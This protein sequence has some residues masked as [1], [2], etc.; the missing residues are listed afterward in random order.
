[1]AVVVQHRST[2]GETEVLRIDCPLVRFVGLRIDDLIVLAVADMPHMLRE[3]QWAEGGGGA[4]GRAGA[5][6]CKAVSRR[7]AWNASQWGLRHQTFRLSACNGLRRVP[8]HSTEILCAVPASPGSLQVKDGTKGVHAATLS[9]SDPGIE[10]RAYSGEW[11]SLLDAPK[12]SKLLDSATATR[13]V[14]NIP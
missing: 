12:Q 10:L 6:V 11:Q 1:M 7:D 13:T 14:L 5:E 4:Q 8:L 2:G 3:M 9:P